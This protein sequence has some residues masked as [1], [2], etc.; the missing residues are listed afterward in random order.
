MDSL[1]LYHLDRGIPVEYELNTF[2]TPHTGTTLCHPQNWL[3]RCDAL[4]RSRHLALI[5]TLGHFNGDN[6]RL[7]PNHQTHKSQGNSKV[8]FLQRQTRLSLNYSEH[9]LSH[10]RRYA[11]PSQ[12]FH[13]PTSSLYS[14]PFLRDSQ[15]KHKLHF[16]C[17]K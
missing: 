7:S 12:L 6:A 5:S 14:Q 8:Y 2:N 10:V 16:P 15:H 9:N 4:F 3:C 17:C 13:N 11:L 1:R